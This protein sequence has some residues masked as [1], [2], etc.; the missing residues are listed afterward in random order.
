MNHF[1]VAI[2]AVSASVALAA[3]AT[4][5][6]AANNLLANG[7]FENTGF[8]GTTSY[9]NVGPAGADHAVPSDFGWSVGNGNV[10]IVSYV[11]YGPAPANGGAYGLDLVGYGSTGQIS[12]TIGTVAGRTYNV[13][14][15]YSSN[16]GISGPAADV[17][18]NGGAI[19]SVT[20]SSGWQTYTGSFLGTGSPMTFALNETLGANNAGVFLDNVSVTAI[21]EPATWAMM[22]I[23]FGGLGAAMRSQRK[24]RALATA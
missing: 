10:D 24:A 4:G 12:Q 19:G 13:S 3:A 8:G 20:G 5:A 9:Y 22:L 18:V 14:F 17:L 21:P 15:D 2:L 16:P 7:G 23:G 11:T 1:R 6:Q